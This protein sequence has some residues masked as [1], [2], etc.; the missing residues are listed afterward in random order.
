MARLAPIGPTSQRETGFVA[1][2]VPDSFVD[3]L[4]E[5]EL[6]RWDGTA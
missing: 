3:P 4:P 1:Y 5:Q 6:E 2:G